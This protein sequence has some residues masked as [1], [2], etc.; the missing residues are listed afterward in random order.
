MANQE[1]HKAVA[2]RLFEEVWNAQHLDVT[3]ELL[4]P[5]YLG[6]ERNA[7]DTH[8][9]SGMRQ[10]AQAFR[11][12]FADAR[13]TII[14]AIAEA[15]SVVLHL[16]VQATHTATARPITISGMVLYRIGVQLPRARCT[17]RLQK[18]PDLAREAVSCNAGLGG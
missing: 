18:R 17:E 5:T 16:H 7:A 9:P 15:D 12:R 14:D 3:N 4:A 6:H 10:V 11:D 2:V 1:D 13:F 8:G